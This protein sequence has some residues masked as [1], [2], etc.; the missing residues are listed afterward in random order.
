MGGE[1]PVERGQ[2]RGEKTG[3]RRGDVPGEKRRRGGRG[4]KGRGER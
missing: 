3:E 1:G 2:R 4:E